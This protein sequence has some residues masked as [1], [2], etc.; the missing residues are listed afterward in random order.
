MKYRIT[1]E[2]N[3]T[4][5]KTVDLEAASSDEAFSKAY[6]MPYTKMS[7]EIGVEEIP[8]GPSVIGV[9]FIYQDMMTKE[10]FTDRIM[11]FAD[12]EQQAVEYYNRY[13][14]GRRFWFNPGKTESDGKHV[15]GSVKGTY[16]AG[17]PRY[18]AD[19]TGGKK[20]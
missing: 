17:C 13:Y 20:C 4:V 6:Y 7:E 9:E 15:R 14:R 12:S 10:M 3:D 5:I 11:I 19:A 2:K 18:D 8:T 1:F 16:F